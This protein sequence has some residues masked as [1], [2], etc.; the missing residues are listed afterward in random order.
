MPLSKYFGGHGSKV[1]ANMKEQYGGEKA[2]KVFYAT[3]NKRK[4]H[5]KSDSKKK[6]T[7]E[8]GPSPKTCRKHGV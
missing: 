4:K 3:S 7:L 2:E 8:T 6:E 5:E 1:M